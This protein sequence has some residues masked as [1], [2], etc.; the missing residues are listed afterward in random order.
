[1]KKATFL[2][3]AVGLVLGLSVPVHADVKVWSGGSGNWDNGASWDLPGEPLAGTSVTIAED[4]STVTVDS[5]GNMAGGL[6]VDNNAALAVNT[7]GELTVSGTVTIG[8]AGSLTTSGTG[9]FNPLILI[10]EGTTVLGGTGRITGLNATA[11]TL[12]V[13]SPLNPRIM[14]VM[15]AVTLNAAAGISASSRLTLDGTTVNVTGVADFATGTGATIVNN[16]PDL[17]I[18]GAGHLTIM[19]AGGGGPL[20]P[21]FGDLVMDAGA[22]L[23]LDGDSGLGTGMARFNSISG[24]GT[25]RGGAIAAGT[26]NTGTIVVEGDL[27]VGATSNTTWAPG[28]LI[29]VTAG[30][31][32]GNLAFE[33]GWTLTID[34][35]SAAPTPGIFYDVLTYQGALTVGGTVETGFAPLANGTVDSSA[36]AAWAS[37][38]FWYNTNDGRAFLLTAVDRTWDGTTGTWSTNHWNPG[39]TGPG[40][41]DNMIVPS[42]EVTV[43]A[44]R[45]GRDGAE[46]LTVSGS[47]IVNV[48]HSLDVILA[49]TV[50]GGGTLN[51]NATSTLTSHSVSVLG[52]AVA[53]GGT[54]TLVGGRTIDIL[55]GTVSSVAGSTITAPTA[56]VSGSGILLSGG[57]LNVTTLNS[58]AST[59]LSGTGTIGTLNVTGGTTTI[60]SL[61]VD[62]GN[63]NVESGGTLVATAAIA[64]TGNVSV[65]GTLGTNSD[66]TAGELTLDGATVN[67]S[68][69]AD[70]TA[71]GSTSVE[72]EPDLNIAGAGHLTIRSSG[73]L[74]AAFGD[75]VMEAGAQLTLDSSDGLG[76]G[77]ASFASISGEGTIHGAVT[78]AGAVDP[79]TISV[80][81]DLVA[82]AASNVTWQI[83]DLIDVA[84]ATIYAGDVTLED[85]VTLTIDEAGEPAI[86]VAYPVI[87]FEGTLTLGQT[88]AGS[89]GL[90]TN[91][92]LNDVGA[93]DWSTAN[94]WYNSS[95]VFIVANAN[96]TWDGSVGNWSGNNW[97][98]ASPAGPT[99]LGNMAV[100]AGTVVVDAP[101]TGTAGALSLTMGGGTV[102]V[103]NPLDVVQDTA[104][105]G[106]VLA[107]NS[108]LS[109]G[110]AADVGA[111]GTLQ[112][113]PTGTVTAPTVNSLGT[114]NVEGANAGAR[115]HLNSP[116]VNSSG[117]FNV[118]GFGQVTANTVNLTDG[119]ASFGPDTALAITELNIAGGAV[120]T[121]GM[122]IDGKLN[123]NSG[124]LR[125]TDGNVT[126]T[127]DL[128]LIGGTVTK[129]GGGLA[130]VSSDTKIKTKAA[131][132]D[133]QN[134]RLQLQVSG[135]G[136]GF[137][138][139][140]EL[141]V[142]LDAGNLSVG[143]LTTWE[144]MGETPG[145][146]TTTGDPVVEMVAGHQAVTLDG[147]G[148][149]F[150]GPLSPDSIEGSNARSVE[151]W[152]YNPD[153]G[154]EET[155][156]AW[157][158]RGGPDGS[159]VS[160]NYHADGSWGAV[161]QWGGGPD[162]SW[163]G[164]PDLNQWH[165]LVY[166]QSGSET[167][168]Y[169]DGVLKNSETVGINSH[170]DNPIRI[171]AQNESQGGG[172]PTQQYSGSIAQVRIHDGV[173]SLEDVQENFAAGVDASTGSSFGDLTMADGTELIL[174]DALGV[175]AGASFASIIAGNNATI[176]GSPIT[177]SFVAG[178]SMTIA[179]DATF[180]GTSAIGTGLAIT[181]NL[182]VEVDGRFAP[183]GGA[184]VGGNAAVDGTIVP[185][186][187]SAGSPSG[188]GGTT[189]VTGDFDMLPGGGLEWITFDGS[190][191]EN[192]SVGGQLTLP[193]SWS[194]ILNPGGP[195][196]LSS[197]EYTL[198]TYDTL[199]ADL[200]SFEPTIVSAPG[201]PYA[202]LLLPVTR[203]SST[204]LARIGSF[205]SSKPNRRPSG[206]IPSAGL[207]ATS[208]L[209]GTGPVSPGPHRMRTLRQW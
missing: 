130:I 135:V 202:D 63:V 3:A 2:T 41:L 121:P 120:S 197:G 85:G 13:S 113:N 193:E 24:D 43:A 183:T 117:A 62:L 93:G 144:N 73:G 89:F 170:A 176:T 126:A 112:V 71:A 25:I 32:G 175:A 150:E 98:P 105:N 192:V 209:V 68:G 166:T 48:D 190:Q 184:A 172:N 99:Q 55:G 205:C 45:V 16:A 189:V 131:N 46:G 155:M 50:S 33:D 116:M 164:M 107:V 187:G 198:F 157:A 17:N 122:T 124:Q 64:T 78:A 158:H 143:P 180:T 137:A 156:V 67:I 159:N 95:S 49:T 163:N 96:R 132:V 204:C 168:V 29:D 196:A 206:Q 94:V 186:G 104:V 31:L 15:D 194:V 91:G 185:A 169:A 173:M 177:P 147:S 125:I 106:G 80:E 5:A 88:A 7:G 179:G 90:V 142:F 141:L 76:A 127:G 38:R 200:V 153:T 30:A 110:S 100:N 103:A 148:D 65:F 1:M 27:I 201:S 136:G 191:L 8:P 114:I 109:V 108:T 23:T 79:G 208:T 207:T 37:A 160:F 165:H 167:R 22:Q 171:G 199:V 181:G 6:I 53:V 44:D 19:A 154:G 40:Q 35:S 203:R 92:V 14:L 34:G 54:G 36:A 21:T 83:G 145:D 47:G 69:V 58:S 86:G 123:L 66:V 72:N 61:A 138:I 87:E 56:N 97:L 152:T 128:A 9:Q 52:G 151:V 26:V 11:G 60:S 59:A 134:G 42:G 57:Q 182:S 82:R 195:V 129:L 28:D 149:W 188:T 118:N 77:A 115:G 162:L 75:L 140:G 174:K 133:V 81:G 84:A 101:Y 70:F 161:G 139:A 10:T 12:T 146:F 119:T 102:D 178:N 18:T 74:G 4:G 51:V 111:A 20:S 39:P